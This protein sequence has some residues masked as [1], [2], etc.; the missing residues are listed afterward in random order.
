MNTFKNFIL[1]HPIYKLI[2]HQ[3]LAFFG[4]K[5][6]FISVTLKRKQS[7]VRNEMFCGILKTN[8]KI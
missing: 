7:A 1:S 3:N 6:S 8:N 5:K 2:W 4:N